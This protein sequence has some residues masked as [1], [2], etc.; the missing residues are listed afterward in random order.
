MNKTRP[1]GSRAKTIVVLPYVLFL[2][3]A[4]ASIGCGVEPSKS[5]AL[6]VDAQESPVVAVGSAPGCDEFQKL[7]DRTYD[8]K[9]TKL[10]E[11]EQTKKS[12]DMDAV[13]NKVKADP[14]NTLPCLVA[15]L[16][17]PTANSFFRF[18]G[19]TLLVSLDRSEPAK[20]L[21]IRSFARSELEDIVLSDWIAYILRFGLEGLDTSEAAEA[22]LKAKDPFYYLPQHGTLK[23][24]RYIGALAIFG[25][26]DE[27]FATPALAGIASQN[28]HPGR[29]LAVTLLSKQVTAEAFDALARIDRAGLS[30]RSLSA[31]KSTLTSPVFIEKRAGQPKV[32][33][34]EFIKALSELSEGKGSNFMDLTTKVT[35]GEKDAVA[36]LLPEDVALVRKARRY[37]A[38]TGT[39]HTPEWY[40]SFTDILMVMVRQPEIEKGSA[41]PKE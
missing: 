8:F 31:I 16:E 35:D 14:K 22:W 17:S 11:A 10:T 20:K 30:D 4:A 1:T 29:D 27:K 7:I 33:R 21:L 37:F 36:V 26:M 13:W 6:P 2:I 5:S 41:G 3:L 28:G 15:A 23:V 32:T 18:D 9:P 25:S 39:P 12:A 38:S 19:S 40:Q 24:D 34:N